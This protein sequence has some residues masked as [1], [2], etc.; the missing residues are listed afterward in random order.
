VLIDTGIIATITG[1]SDV[2]DRNCCATVTADYDVLACDLLSVRITRTG[3]TGS[4][5]AG[6][7]VTITMSSNV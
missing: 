1:P 3:D 6:A 2:G 5:E 7:A 4:L